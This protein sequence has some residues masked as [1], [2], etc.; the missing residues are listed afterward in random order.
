MDLLDTLLGGRG[1][2]TDGS[3][4]QNPLTSMV[5]SVFN[6]HVGAG[7]H[8]QMPSVAEEH[9]YYMEQPAYQ[10]GDVSVW[11]E[12]YSASEVVS[13]SVSLHVMSISVSRRTPIWSTNQLRLL[14]A[15][16]VS[17]RNVNSECSYGQSAAWRP[18]D[19][20]AA[21]IHDDATRNGY[22]AYDART[23]NLLPRR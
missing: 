14:F 23:G 4:T 10:P 8:G 11:H 1:C 19:V 21:A 5:D 20:A 12:N 3:L 6:S 13:N 2:S 15:P 22:V 7:Q 18:S 9:G 16:S 17:S